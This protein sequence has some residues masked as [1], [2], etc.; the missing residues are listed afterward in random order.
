MLEEKMGVASSQSQQTAVSTQQLQQPPSPQIQQNREE[1]TSPVQDKCK[2]PQPQSECWATQV[3]AAE[4]LAQSP[5]TQPPQPEF[6]PVPQT[7]V[8]YCCSN[9]SGILGLDFCRFLLDSYLGHGCFIRT[10][11][12]ILIVMVPLAA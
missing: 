12:V 9:S 6:R 1:P 11:H 8:S 5:Q 10:V 4:K 2:S 7:Q 3:E